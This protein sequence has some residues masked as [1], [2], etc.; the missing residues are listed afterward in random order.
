M[1]EEY[2]TSDPFE[3][4]KRVDKGWSGKTSPVKVLEGSVT[5]HNVGTL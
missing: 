1:I 2:D 4:L 3:G 5:G